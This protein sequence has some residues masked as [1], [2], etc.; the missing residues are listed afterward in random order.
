MGG[1]LSNIKL[2]RLE[3]S[4]EFMFALKVFHNDTQTAK[5]WFYTEVVALN[6]QRPVDLLLDD[7]GKKRVI[8]ILNKIHFG[9]FS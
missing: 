6:G 7:K 1:I 2:N 9:E 8:D 4:K 3:S 5:D